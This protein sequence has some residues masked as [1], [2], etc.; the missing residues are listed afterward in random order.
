MVAS[1]IFSI[2]IASFPL[3]LKMCVSSH[4][5]TI[6]RQM[7]GSHGTPEF[8]VLTVE[9][10]S[11]HPFDT[12]NKGMVSGCLENFFTPVFKN[13]RSEYNLVGGNM[14]GRYYLESGAL[15]TSGW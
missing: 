15:K 6:K 1:D 5:R 13:T 2:F 3:T 12:K 9:L 8:W 7:I 14:K 10:S 4:A 11:F